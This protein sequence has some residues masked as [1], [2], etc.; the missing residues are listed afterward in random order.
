[1]TLLP[2][3]NPEDKPI[4]PPPLPQERPFSSLV[5]DAIEAEF[6]RFQ[7]HMVPLAERVR[8]G[9]RLLSTA[10]NMFKKIAESITDDLAEKERLTSLSEKIV[11]FLKSYVAPRITTQLVLSGD[12]IPVYRISVSGPLEFSMD[13]MPHD[14]SLGLQAV[15]DQV[16][17]EYYNSTLAPIVGFTM[18]MLAK[19]GVVPES[20]EYLLP[21][22][23]EALKAPLAGLTEEDV[24]EDEEEDKDA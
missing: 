11:N 18:V 14:L 19:Y 1:M 24:E 23:F 21:S 17:E 16:H 12:D 22:S 7:S 9:H 10:A 5:A 8:A 15:R 6:K 3:D 13:V 4:V 2:E 20:D